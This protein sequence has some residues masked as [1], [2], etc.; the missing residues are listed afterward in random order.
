MGSETSNYP[1]KTKISSELLSGRNHKQFT[2]QTN[3]LNG[4]TTVSQKK[5]FNWAR[6]FIDKNSHEWN[7]R[8]IVLR[9]S[10]TLWTEPAC[11]ED[12]DRALP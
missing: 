9:H 2:T 1:T 10:G 7:Q 6:D 12:T 8:K 11:P 3:H 5:K 4:S